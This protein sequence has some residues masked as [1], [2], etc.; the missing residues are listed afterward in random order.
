MALDTS[1]DEN[2]FPSNLLGLLAETPVIKD[3]LKGEKQ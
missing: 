3:R 2:N 1:E